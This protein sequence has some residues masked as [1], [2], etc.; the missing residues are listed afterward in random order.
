MEHLMNKSANEINMLA[1]TMSED[2][3]R[4]MIRFYFSRHLMHTSETNQMKVSIIFES[5][6]TFGLS[7]NDM[8][9]INSIWQDPCEGYIIF[10][11]EGGNWIDFDD[12][13][14]NELIR[15]MNIFDSLEQY[16]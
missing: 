7:T 15:I 2:D 4:Q 1:K 3:V 5:D 8:L 10:E 16:L 6:E 12:L 14:I 9:R 11:F 13:S